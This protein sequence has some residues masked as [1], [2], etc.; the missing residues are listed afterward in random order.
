LRRHFPTSAGC[1]LQARP[2]TEMLRT[3]YLS[4]VKASQN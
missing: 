1:V 4:D 3:C 2:V